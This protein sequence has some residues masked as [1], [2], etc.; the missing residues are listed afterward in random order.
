LNNKTPALRDRRSSG[1]LQEVFT[2]YE[3]LRR[4]RRSSLFT[5]HSGASGGLHFLRDTP[6]LQHAG[7][8]FTMQTPPAVK[9]ISKNAVLKVKTGDAV[10]VVRQ[11]LR[12][13]N[14][15]K[16][17]F[18][19][20]QV[21]KIY[22]QRFEVDMKWDAPPR[23]SHQRVPAGDIVSMEYGKKKN[24]EFLDGEK[25]AIR[26]SADV[27]PKGPKAPKPEP[28]S[29]EELSELYKQLGGDE[30]Q[31]DTKIQQVQTKQGYAA[32]PLDDLRTGAA[33]DTPATVHCLDSHQILSAL[34]REN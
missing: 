13:T 29:K 3:T 16:T 22:A 32:A 7:L 12:T 2:F 18:E 28:K 8:P 5:R 6:A 26:K 25:K 27:E 19:S 34:R 24:Q 17:P 1:G 10:M 9:K 11:G 15:R 33:G 30:H 14:R 21:C 23:T 4:F 31:L 20:G